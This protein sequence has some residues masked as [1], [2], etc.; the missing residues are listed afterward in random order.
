MRNFQ[1][2]GGIASLIEAGTF[3]FGFA[4]LVTVLA[5][6][7]QG[8]LDGI[9]T[10][11]FLAEHTT[12]YYIWNLVIYVLF[13]F[14][15]VVLALALHERLSDASPRLMR[16]ATALGLI[17]AGLVIASGM[18][19]NI[20]AAAVTELLPREPEVAATVW[21]AVATVTRG[22]GGG[23][24][25]VGG[26]W[27]A[28]LSLVALKSGKLPKALSYLGVVSGTAGVVTLVPALTD[29]GAVFGLG[30]IAWFLW[31]GVVLLGRRY[32]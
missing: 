10:V 1:K 24:E 14:M 5:P 4:L 3:L 8:E 27:V 2:A 13:G 26:V 16:L 28:L 30:L 6:L 17:W 23:N 21:I 7:F 15:L 20:G 19:A 31:T 22:L 29:V 32:A 11:R 9:A 25:V 18:V 12:L